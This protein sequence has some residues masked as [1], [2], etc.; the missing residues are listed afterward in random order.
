M[1]V[2]RSAQCLVAACAQA[3]G[4]LAHTDYNYFS[5]YKMCRN[6][7]LHE[8]SG[9]QVGVNS[10]TVTVSAPNSAALVRSNHP[11][12]YGESMGLCRFKYSCSPAGLAHAVWPVSPDVGRWHS[13]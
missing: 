6:N 9:P 12:C 2:A 8:L 11:Y 5:I 13:S 1:D 7:N 10:K 4:I 3:Q